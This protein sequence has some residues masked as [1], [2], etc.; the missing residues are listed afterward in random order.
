MFFWKRIAVRADRR[1]QR[2]EYVLLTVC[3]SL[4]EF[5][6]LQRRIILLSRSPLPW[7]AI[8][9]PAAH[10]PASDPGGSRC[11]PTPLPR[12]GASRPRKSPGLFA[13][14]FANS[15]TRDPL[16][17]LTIETRSSIYS[18]QQNRLGGSVQKSEGEMYLAGLSRFV[19][20]M[21]ASKLL[22]CMYSYT[23]IRS[24]PSSQ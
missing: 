5:R 11:R 12:A 8:R 1:Q 9:H 13:A 3:L 2:Q 22:L 6:W 16:V 19:P 15:A 4:S 17:S 23:R 20:N 14:S 10:W 24:P 21:Y 7:P 18:C